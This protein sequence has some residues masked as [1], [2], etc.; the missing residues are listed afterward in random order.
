MEQERQLLS[1]LRWRQAV[2]FFQEDIVLFNT[3]EDTWHFLSFESF[4]INTIIHQI[5]I[6]SHF[7]S[8]IVQYWGQRVTESLYQ[9][10][11]L[12][13]SLPLK[14]PPNK[15]AI[16]MKMFALRM[17]FQEKSGSSPKLPSQQKILL[18]PSCRKILEL[19]H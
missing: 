5:F 2:H 1:S 8:T 7:H 19:S 4:H 6:A 16:Y 14:V 13:A 3:Y 12:S 18:S 9:L 10:K 17:N 11:I 15:H